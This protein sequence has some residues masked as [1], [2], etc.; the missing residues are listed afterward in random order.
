VS[1]AEAVAVFGYHQVDR[2]LDRYL[3]G[4]T[5]EGDGA[6]LD[7]VDPVADVEDLGVVV[8]R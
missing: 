8:G 3:G 6:V 2:F 5:V 1:R 4:G 7:Q